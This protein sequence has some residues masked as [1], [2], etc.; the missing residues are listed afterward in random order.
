MCAPLEG[1]RGSFSNNDSE[2]QGHGQRLKD[3]VRLTLPE[4][5]VPS[6]P[7]SVKD[8]HER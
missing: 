5:S 3:S 1:G 8:T 4:S 2:T 7:I 6:V